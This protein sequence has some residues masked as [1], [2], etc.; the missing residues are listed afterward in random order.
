[1]QHLRL[2]LLLSTFA[3]ALMGCGQMGG[4]YHPTAEDAAARNGSE[5]NPVE[6]ASEEPETAEDAG[7]EATPGT[8]QAQ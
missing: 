2:A 1:M 7:D 8:T 6:P 5:P 4:L 3:A